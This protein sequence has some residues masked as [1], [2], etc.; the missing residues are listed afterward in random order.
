MIVATAYFILGTVMIIEARLD[1]FQR[2]RK[3]WMLDPIMT[4]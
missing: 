3:K 4:D 1:D 2:L